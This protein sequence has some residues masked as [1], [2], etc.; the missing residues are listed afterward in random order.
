MASAPDG[1]SHTAARPRHT[2]ASSGLLGAAERQER[3]F[4][5]LRA[6]L[7]HETLPALD[8]DV[9]AHVATM[10]WAHLTEI[11]RVTRSSAWRRGLTVPATAVPHQVLWLLMGGDAPSP[12]QLSGGRHRTLVDALVA[13]LETRFE[14]EAN[15]EDNQGKRRSGTYDRLAARARVASRAP[16]SAPIDVPALRAMMTDLTG[17]SAKLDAALHAAKGTLKPLPLPSPPPHRWPAH[18]VGTPALIRTGASP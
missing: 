17:V 6:S 11:L 5:A 15:S 1:S 13:K 8:A 10:T 16:W 2:V 4:A 7:A 12:L 14:S 18:P 9:R 3:L